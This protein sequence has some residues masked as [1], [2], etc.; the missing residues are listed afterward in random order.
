MAKIGNISHHDNF[1]Y[2]TLSLTVLLFG[3]ALSHQFFD[4]SSQ[5]LMLTSIAMVLL[6]SVLGVKENLN[7]KEPAVFLPI[8]SCTL[9]IVGYQLNIYHFYLFQ[10]VMLLIF[11]GYMAYH[12]AVQ[13]IF[14]GPI[15]LNKI[16]GSI[17][18]YYL[19]GLT[20][21]ILYTLCQMTIGPAFSNST[22]T[23]HWYLLLPDYIYYSFVILS[24]VG[25]GD[26]VPSQPI[27]KFLAYFEAIIGQFYLAILVASL[28][29]SAATQRKL[30]RSLND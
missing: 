29:S 1:F 19:I 15:D 13:V 18:L 22:E 14:T 27:T 9:I 24:T 23:Q 5:R 30:K 16:L 8:L 7:F 3:I 21:A 4:A 10:L 2:L 25:F 6:V 11:F 12:V 26:I 20:F 17:C 28:V